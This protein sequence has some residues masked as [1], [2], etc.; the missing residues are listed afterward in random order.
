MSL[1]AREKRQYR[2]RLQIVADIIEIA[3]NGSRK[4]R[5]M[6]QGNL[7]FDLLQRYLQML[8][9][10]GLLQTQAGDSSTYIATEKGL[11]FLE[12]Y[13]G[14][15]KYGEMTEN[16]RRDLKRSLTSILEKPEEAAPA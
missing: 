6:Y 10:Y 7:S 16:N 3:R 15:R 2:T 5:I 4:T 11:Q 13:S 8:V 1:I 12:A 9:N 14:L